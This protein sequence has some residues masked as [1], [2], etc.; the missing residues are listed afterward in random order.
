MIVKISNALS[1]SKIL[2]HRGSKYLYLLVVL[3]AKAYRLLFIGQS[4]V[5][6]PTI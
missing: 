4:H 1:R 3:F 5:V 2:Q 6:L